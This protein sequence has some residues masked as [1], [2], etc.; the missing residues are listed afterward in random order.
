MQVSA[1]TYSIPPS[2][3]TSQA[4]RQLERRDRKVKLIRTLRAAAYLGSLEAAD[5]P[6][7]DRRCSLGRL[8]AATD[9]VLRQL[10]NPAI[11]QR[12]AR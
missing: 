11:S 8:V 12:K 9:E 10:C 7:L 5:E 4:I 1:P 3:S 2:I 6:G